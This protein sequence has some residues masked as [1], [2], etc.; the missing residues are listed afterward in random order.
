LD[1]V[2]ILEGYLGQGFQL[3]PSLWKKLRFSTTRMMQI[4]EKIIL[5]ISFSQVPAVKLLELPYVFHLQ[6]DNSS[7]E[8]PNDEIIGFANKPDV[9][10]QTVG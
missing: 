10:F 5:F 8:H 2:L 4:K 3:E 9:S 1:R 6:V 7:K